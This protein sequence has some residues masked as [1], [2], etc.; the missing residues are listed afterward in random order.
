M[1]FSRTLEGYIQDDA[2]QRGTSTTAAP[3][4]GCEKYRIDARNTEQNGSSPLAATNRPLGNDANMA[5]LIVRALA[6]RRATFTRAH[7]ESFADRYI[8]RRRVDRRCAISHVGRAF[9]IHAR[10]SGVFG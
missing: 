1:R 5:R 9:S 8:R 6:D 10:Y 3:N 4:F 2:R 7:P